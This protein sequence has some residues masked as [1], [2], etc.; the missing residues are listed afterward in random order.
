M[1]WV[2]WVQRL[3]CLRRWWSD[4]R[5]AATKRRVPRCCAARCRYPTRRP[6]SI[7]SSR[8]WDEPAAPLS[9]NSSHV[10]CHVQVSIYV[11]SINEL[12]D[13][14]DKCPCPVQ[15]TLQCCVLAGAILFI[16]MGW[17]PLGCCMLL[18]A[19]AGIVALGVYG[20]NIGLVEKQLQVG[21]T[22]LGV[23][24]YCDFHILHECVF[25]RLSVGYVMY[26]IWWKCNA[27]LKVNKTS[28]KVTRYRQKPFIFDITITSCETQFTQK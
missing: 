7:S 12:V 27:S 15:F 3:W 13:H 18:P 21:W 9:W 11:R 4:A 26:D 20:T 10:R 16:F 17:G 28:V 22:W 14:I 24:V 1:P 19:A 8:R 6:A 25:L 23:H 2:K 5:A